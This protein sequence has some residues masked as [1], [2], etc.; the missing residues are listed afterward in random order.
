MTAISTS[1]GRRAVRTTVAVGAV[2]LGF[3]V[4]AACQKPTPN[5]HFTLNTHTDS[6]EADHD[7]HDGDGLGADLVETCLTTDDGVEFGTRSGDTFRI[8]VDP[9][10]AED[11]WV[12][13]I[14]GFPAG[15]QEP[16]S[17]TYQ[18]FDTDELF[19]TATQLQSQAGVEPPAEGEVDITVG[20]LR[21]DTEGLNLDGTSLEEFQANTLSSLQSTWTV[22]LKP[23]E[24]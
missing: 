12:V 7:C 18:T 6:F 15:T 17:S 24:H 3:V 20:Q 21:D 14:N 13:L 4:L 2:S 5:A 9:K 19:S 1:R 10:V 16:Y 11:G 8:G 23:E 22:R